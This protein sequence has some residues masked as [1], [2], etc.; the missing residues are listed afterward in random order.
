MLT[1]TDTIPFKITRVIGLVKGS[2]HYNSSSFSSTT[3]EIDK[4]T[5]YATNAI[6]LDAKN[7]GANAVIGIKVS[8]G[9][10]EVSAIVLMLGTAVVYDPY[11]PI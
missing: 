6:A 7:K 5:D 4:A 9:F 10:D 3:G 8:L 1:T 2:A 11:Q